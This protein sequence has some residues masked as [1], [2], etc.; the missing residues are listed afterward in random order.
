MAEQQN[1]PFARVANGYDPKQVAAFAAEALSWKKE[2][3]AL[4][5]EVAAAAK[6]VD[7][8]ESVIGS[9]EEV[10]R[11][12]AEIVEDAERRAEALIADAEARASKIVE[13]AENEA[14]RILAMAES[15]HA[16]VEPEPES[17]RAD[18][19]E[20]RQPEAEN[21]WLA[22]EPDAQPIPDPVE[23]IFE[24]TEEV[25]PTEVDVSLE[26]RAAGAAN[27]WKRRGVVAPSE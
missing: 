8:Y 5:S 3:V 24:P 19:P 10:E 16:S 11:E 18:G 13:E 12:A 23:Q 21:G 14:A 26:R 25:A 9:V 17:G 15:A 7:R 4:R 2:L 6:L 22:P 20:I 27:L 1:S